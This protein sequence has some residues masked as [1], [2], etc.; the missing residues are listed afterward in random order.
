MQ[1]A[2]R[3]FPSLEM[4]LVL[5]PRGCDRLTFGRDL[6]HG[7]LLLPPNLLLLLLLSVTKE[8]GYS[9]S[10]LLQ[11]VMSEIC[12]LGFIPG[13]FGAPHKV[14]L[15]GCHGPGPEARTTSGGVGQWMA[16]T[17]GLGLS[18]PWRGTC[19]QNHQLSS[20]HDKVSAEGNV[21][22]RKEVRET[23]ARGLEQGHCPKR[24]GRLG[25]LTSHRFEGTLQKGYGTGGKKGF[26]MG[27]TGEIRSCGLPRG[28]LHGP[29][30]EWL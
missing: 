9:H 29:R 18:M 14:Q 16:C 2:D 25:C 30:T 3:H 7:S 1:G 13:D 4:L 26:R 15:W 20:D 6:Y 8:A 12:R 21:S 17:A 27:Y 5:L 23:S 11:S 10:Q 28:V 22:E 19:H 24:R